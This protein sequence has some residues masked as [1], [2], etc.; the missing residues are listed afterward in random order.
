MQCIHNIQNTYLTEYQSELVQ[1]CKCFFGF[2]FPNQNFSSNFLPS[3]S[4]NQIFL[5]FNI[6]ILLVRL[7]L[8]N[9]PFRT[10]FLFWEGC[11]RMPHVHF[12]FLA[13]KVCFSFTTFTCFSENMFVYAFLYLS[14]CVHASTW[15][16][17]IPAKVKFFLSI[18]VLQRTTLDCCLC[19][20]VVLE[21]NFSDTYWNWKSRQWSR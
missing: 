20:S 6:F 2:L 1:Q 13:R 19:C 3:W 5:G 7:S 9:N 21:I 12:L 17:K 14:K 16:S 11:L 8:K 15:F 10:F 18:A 4:I